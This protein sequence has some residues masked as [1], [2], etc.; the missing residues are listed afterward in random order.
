M[1]LITKSRR[2]GTPA[3]RSKRVLHRCMWLIAAAKFDRCDRLVGPRVSLSCNGQTASCAQER[4]KVWFNS[5]TAQFSAPRLSTR[6]KAIWE[7]PHDHVA[8]TLWSTHARV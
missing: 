4:C 7:T 2:H 8:D 6:V 5:N 1:N 3:Q